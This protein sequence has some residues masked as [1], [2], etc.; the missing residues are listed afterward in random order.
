MWVGNDVCEFV[1]VCV[2]SKVLVDT[3]CSNEHFPKKKKKKE[4]QYNLAFKGVDSEI[5]ALLQNLL[6]MHKIVHNER[7]GV[8]VI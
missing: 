3:K 4:W 5:K 7:R 2:S 8:Y 1:A 6:A